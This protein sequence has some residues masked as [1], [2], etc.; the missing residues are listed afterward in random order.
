MI[1]PISF[2]GVA[3]NDGFFQSDL[4]GI[5]DADKTLTLN[6]ILGD[7]Q[8]FGRSKA[9]ERKL[10]LNIVAGAENLSK[11]TALNRMVVGNS[12]KPLVI[13]TDIG[14]LIGYAEVTNFAWAD[15]T[16]LLSS[17]QLTMPDP[18]WYTLQPDSLSLEPAITNGVIF[19]LSIKITSPWASKI[20]NWIDGHYQF[21]STYTRATTPLAVNETGLVAAQFHDEL[22]RGGYTAPESGS[23][24]A[25]A[26]LL[27]G[28]LNAYRATGTAKWLQ[29][30][31]NLA[32][33]MVAVL[34]R[35]VSI[36]ASYDGTHIYLPHWLFNVKGD[37]QGEAFYTDK[38]VFFQNGVGVFTS[39]YTARKVFSVRDLNATLVWNNPYSAINGT[40]YA[41]ESYST[42]GG[43]TFTVTLT[44]KTYTG[45]CYVIYSDLGGSIIPKNALNEAWPI[46]R[47]LED[48]EIDCAV[49]SVWWTYD[50]FKLLAQ[51][52]GAPK[53][54]SATAYMQQIIP[55]VM[56]VNDFDDWF[57]T[58]AG[59]DDPFSLAGT[60]FSSDRNGAT[61]KRST[62]TGAVDLTIPSGTGAVQYGNGALSDEWD[63]DSYIELTIASTASG[64][65]AV[66]IDTQSE[67]SANTRTSAI[68]ALS[69]SGTPVT[70]MLHRTDFVLSSGLIWDLAYKTDASTYGVNKDTAS[71]VVTAI[72]ADMSN[73]S[74]NYSVSSGGYAQ[75]QPYIPDGVSFSGCPP[76]K[77]TAN[78]NLSLRLKDAN[79][80]WWYYTLPATSTP[81]TVA[82]DLSAFSTSGPQSNQGTPPATFV[83]P[84]PEVVFAFAG[85]GTFALYRIGTAASPAVGTLIKNVM[86]DYTGS[87]AQTLSVY[88]ARFL[89][90]KTVKY[91]PYVAPFTV[92]C[93]KNQIVTWRGAP[94]SGYQAPW[95]WQDIG[96]PDGADTVLQFLLDAQ[97][98]YATIT[99]VRGPFAPCYLWDRWDTQD[100]GAPGTWTWN[101]PDPNTFWG[102]YQYRAIEGVA[103]ALAANPPLSVAAQIVTD[104]FA[105]IN[106]YWPSADGQPPDYFPQTGA[107]VCQYE[108]PHCVA[109]LM[110]AAIYAHQSRSIPAA[111]T[112]PIIDRCLQYLER[113]YVSDNT[114][115]VYGTWSTDPAAHTWYEFWGGEILTALQMALDYLGGDM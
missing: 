88:R 83:S 78:S 92:N 18:H 54:Q 106:T 5:F 31:E 103:R 4:R 23:S 111:T 59:T 43:K 8:V 15:D 113:L 86:V 68:I 91:A 115:I 42:D 40:S 105:M 64:T 107:P 70:T 112:E 30:A 67:Y 27:R 62:D 36:P 46:W 49:D 35:G 95:V 73:I 22:G 102:G 25:Q 24:E 114:S 87:S 76:V 20:L 51:L 100:Y 19:P 47:L 2:N 89:P 6:D 110:R 21:L 79:N 61:I 50:D 85:A 13:D 37:Y 9:S 34:F 17:C 90:Q 66:N 14:R 81:V 82:P 77:Y 94:Y 39:A 71:T 28:A 32:D 98:E 52:T 58:N 29:Y 60:Y 33:R 7:G 104:F 38:Q 1:S 3:L 26:L 96:S 84:Q 57:M 56:N 101:G 109:L 93:L 48:T 99:G 108:E 80:W 97:N 41:V 69:G 53:W 16:P 11:I 65:V 55:A 10:V 44:D 72:S 63:D 45:T 74:A 75:F 12:L